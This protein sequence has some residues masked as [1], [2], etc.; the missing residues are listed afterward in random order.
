MIFRAFLLILALASGL[1]Q[2][3]QYR[4]ID[5]KGR[6][7]YSDTPPPPTARS[8]QKLDLAAPPAQPAQ[9]P[10]ELARLQKEFPVTLY[11]APTCVELC[12]A[13]RDLLAK[14]GIP[15]K[16]IQVWDVETHEALKKASGSTEVPTISVGRTAFK[17][18]EQGAYDS[19]L[20]SAG[21]PR[22]GILPARSQAAPPRPEGYV[23]P[24]ER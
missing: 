12:A 6:V 15:F 14:R 2:A 8:A 24:G 1:A 17:G 16:E 19:L 13:A 5:E 23:P 10:F 4:W 11:T 3:Q 21:Y 20:D 18:F 22:A 7:Q 9:E